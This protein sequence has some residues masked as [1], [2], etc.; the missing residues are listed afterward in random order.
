MLIHCMFCITKY[1]EHIVRFYEGHI[2]YPYNA[3]IFTCK[4][5]FLMYLLCNI[6]QF[7]CFY[8]SFYSFVSIFTYICR[9]ISRWFRGRVVCAFDYE[10]GESGSISGSG[11]TTDWLFSAGW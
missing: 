11:G 4:I 1:K 5:N 10:A 7:Q 8:C 6:I 2:E 3:N 9:K